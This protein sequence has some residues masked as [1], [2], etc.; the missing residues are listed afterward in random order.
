MQSMAEAAKARPTTKLV[1]PASLPKLDAP[2]HPFNRLK[3]PLKLHRSS[4]SG[5]ERNKNIRKKSKRP[6]PD[7]RWQK[8]IAREEN[9][10]A[11]QSGM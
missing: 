5:A 3:T 8:R 1:D 4:E 2:T 10:S 6:L 9:N 7:K 11:E